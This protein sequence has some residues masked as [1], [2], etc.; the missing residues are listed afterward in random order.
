MSEAPDKSEKFSVQELCDYVDKRFTGDKS[1]RVSP[2]LARKGEWKN[3]IF[4]QEHY[5]IF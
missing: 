1:W 2:T 4:L 3:Q 5:V